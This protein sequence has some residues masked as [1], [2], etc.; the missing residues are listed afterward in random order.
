MGKVIGDICGLSALFARG[1]S[2]SIRKKKLQL[3]PKSVL[4]Q[5]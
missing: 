1:F 4:F 2:A 3:Y 5:K